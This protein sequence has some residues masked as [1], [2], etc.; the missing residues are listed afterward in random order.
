MKTVLNVK[1]KRKGIEM[2]PPDQVEISQGP[3]IQS[4]VKAMRMMEGM[5]VQLME[6]ML[7]RKS[8]I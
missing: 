4:Q 7:S 8:Y 3:V 1:R 2:V 6:I 5:A